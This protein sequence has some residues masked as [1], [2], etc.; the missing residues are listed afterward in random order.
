MPQQDA[1]LGDGV[2]RPRLVYQSA[3][4][5]DVELTPH[6]ADGTKLSAIA[7]HIATGSNI[8]LILEPGD[9]SRYDV[10]ICPLYSPKLTQLLVARLN[11]TGGFRAAHTVPNPALVGEFA[12]N[13]SADVVAI[14][15]G[16]E[17][18]FFRWWLSCLWL[19]LDN[20]Q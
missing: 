9:L 10:V 4:K 14:N 13:R 3:L 18:K 8:Q 5:G 20:A 2:A 12:F 17:R 1:V 19:E 16:W 15:D 7:H 11:S 6:A